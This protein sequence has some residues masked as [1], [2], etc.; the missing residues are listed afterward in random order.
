MKELA[1]AHKIVEYIVRPQ[2]LDQGVVKAE[3]G[4]QIFVVVR[5]YRQSELG[6]HALGRGE[7]VAAG[8]G[9]VLGAAPRGALYEAAGRGRLRLG[10][11]Q[12]HPQR[13]LGVAQ[14]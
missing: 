6:G 1:N 12:R 7:N 11:V 4:S 13:S 9:D 10:R 5:R 14:G 2:A 8:E 3:A